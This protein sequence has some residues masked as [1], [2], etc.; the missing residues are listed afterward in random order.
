V[1]RDELTVSERRL[2]APKRE[3][4]TMK[5]VKMLGVAALMTAIPHFAYADPP[6]AAQGDRVKQAQVLVDQAY[7]LY[8][9][10]DW[11]KAI[12]AYLESYKLVP[13]ADVL[14]NIASIYDKKLHDKELAIEYYRRHNASTDATPDLIGKATARVSELERGDKS[15]KAAKEDSKKPEPRGSSGGALRALGLVAGGVGVVGLGVGGA[16]GLSA[17]S[18]HS[19]AK[20]AGCGG[21]SCQDATS[22]AQEQDAAR[23]AKMSTALFIAGGA[24]TA[25]GL[26]LYLVAPSSKEQPAGR[27]AAS[28][29]LKLTPAVG[30]NAVGVTLSGVVF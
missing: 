23:A 14:F 4:L 29:S 5:N 8:Q 30:Q 26:T 24:L 21:S 15:G 10:E 17:M 3:G 11:A 7:D 1:A 19:D 20:A 2:A 28:P 6:A 13:T 27:E 16:F 25:V 18:K 12:T 22:Q 9:H